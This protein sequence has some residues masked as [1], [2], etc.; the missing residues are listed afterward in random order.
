MGNLLAVKAREL[1]INQVGVDLVG[2]LAVVPPAQLHHDG[3]SE[4]L[5][6]GGLGAP[7]ARRRDRVAQIGV[8]PIH[9]LGDFIEQLVDGASSAISGFLGSTAQTKFSYC[10]SNSSW[11]VF[12]FLRILGPPRAGIR[13]STT[14]ITGF[15]LL[16]QPQKV[17][18]KTRV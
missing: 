2:Q 4:N 16:A 6:A 8:D 18:P 1:A 15:M 7:P 9:N 12:S 11:S 5:L 13:A 14:A 3:A 10:R 17:K